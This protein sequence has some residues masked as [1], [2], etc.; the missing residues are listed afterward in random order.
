MS[1]A[2][3]APGT[4]SVASEVHGPGAMLWRPWVQQGYAWATRALGVSAPGLSSLCGA[5]PFVQQGPDHI[6]AAQPQV[7]LG[8]L[9]LG[10]V[11]V[12]AAEQLFRHPE[13][14]DAHALGT[15][16]SLGTSPLRRG[17]G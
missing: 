8:G 10:G 9:H 7:G 16:R 6:G 11:G 15:L 2:Q 4:K 3:P 1:A 13:G 12:Q 17:F 5:Q 14:E